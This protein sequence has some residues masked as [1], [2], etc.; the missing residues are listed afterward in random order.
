MFSE[1]GVEARGIRGYVCSAFGLPRAEGSVGGAS[2]RVART[3][4]PARSPPDEGP[5]QPLP[6][7]YDD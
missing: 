4:R 7:E 5:A 6:I 1:K 2:L 3:F